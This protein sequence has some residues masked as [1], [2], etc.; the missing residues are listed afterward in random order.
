MSTPGGYVFVTIGLLR[1]LRS[2][3]ELAAVLGHE[4]AHVTERHMYK[5]ILPKR[6]IG[7]GETVTR[8]LSRGGS[9]FG[10]TLGEAV[11]KG[12]DLLLE[13]GLGQ[14]KE[15]EADDLGVMLAS[16]AGYESGSLYQYLQRI[17]KAEH[18][19]KLS[20][21]HPPFPERLRSLN[22]FMNANGLVSTEMKADLGVLEKRFKAG[23]S[24][25]APIQS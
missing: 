8:F 24:A 7:A 15:E 14:E 4:I 21:T 19:I 25:L 5:A 6:E 3:S 12:L 9:D 11:N 22:D 13:R 17:S 20:K 18:S 23:M 2:E 16:S 10:R 1:Q